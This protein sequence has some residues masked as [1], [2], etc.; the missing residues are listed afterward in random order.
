MALALYIRPWKRDLSQSKFRNSFLFAAVFFTFV[1][2]KVAGF[3]DVI[4]KRPG[5]VLQDPVLQL[6]AP[7]DITWLTFALIYS[8][9]I[10]AFLSLIKTPKRFVVTLQAYAIM[11]IFRM[12][13]MY[14]LPLDPPPTMLILKDPFVEIFSGD[15][16]PLTRDLFFS[17]HT[18]TTFLMFLGVQGRALK[19]LLGLSTAVVAGC[20]LIQHVHYTVD[21]FVAPFCAYAAFRI[22]AW[23]QSKFGLYA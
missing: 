1:L 20:V 14:L 7:H 11:V 18:S 12:T 2:Y 22:S 8:A 17:G 3:L 21:V 4:E 15:G 6:F 13:A 19:T 16:N 5:V 9:I 23:V 10:S